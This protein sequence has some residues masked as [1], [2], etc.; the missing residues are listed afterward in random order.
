[1]LTLA[2]VVELQLTWVMSC[3]SSTLARLWLSLAVDE[4]ILLEESERL[5]IYFEHS[6]SV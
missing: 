5:R 2:L 1:M 3:I 6:V 4:P